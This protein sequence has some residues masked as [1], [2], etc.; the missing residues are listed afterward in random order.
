MYNCE[1]C[2]RELKNKNGL[3]THSGG[4][5]L[6]PNRKQRSYNIKNKGFYYCKFCKREFKGPCGGHIANCI[7]NPK[8]IERKEKR[9]KELELGTYVKRKRKTDYDK[10]VNCKYCD[11]EFKNTTSGHVNVCLLN[12]K[13]IKKKKLLE[14]LPEKPKKNI[15]KR[16][17]KKLSLDHR[18]KISKSVKEFYK[19][20]PDI[21]PYKNINK[22]SYPEKCFR[23]CLEKND[24]KGW[25]QELRIFMYSID[26]AFPEFKMCVE[27]DGN[28]HNLQSVKEKDERRTKY[29]NELGWRVIRFEAKR[30]NKEVYQCVNEVLEMLGEKQIEIP[31]EFFEKQKIRE[32]LNLKKVER[33][34]IKYI[35]NLNKK[36]KNIVE[37][38]NIDFS[39]KE[40]KNKLA[41][42]F[43]YGT[44]ATVRWMKNNMKDFYEEKCYKSKY[45]LLNPRSKK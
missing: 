43:E 4:C 10:I 40:W 41:E 19:N 22:E 27:I 6:N 38:C 11:R 16:K 18:D 23:E 3:I 12:P 35:E 7:K 8:F 17:R 39:K 25:I 32:L 13:N 24:I 28:F 20:N 34:P 2:N 1:F 14:N 26:F 30:V 9:L 44:G 45:V 37:T 36:L 21:H 5:L 15:E 31:E 42:L 29:L 33:Q